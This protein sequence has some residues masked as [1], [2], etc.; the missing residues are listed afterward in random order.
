MRLA[1]TFFFRDQ[2][3]LERAVEHCLPAL[4]GRNHPRIWDAG[5]AHGAGA[6]Y[7]GDSVC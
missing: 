1:F 5:V 7:D 3:V 6:L 2:Q 4:A